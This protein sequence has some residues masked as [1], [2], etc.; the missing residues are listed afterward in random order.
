LWYLARTAIEWRSKLRKF[1]PGFAVA[2][3]LADRKPS[4]ADHCEPQRQVALT[5]QMRQAR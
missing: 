1:D 5:G 4:A 2:A 3:I